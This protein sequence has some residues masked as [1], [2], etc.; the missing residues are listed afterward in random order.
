MALA[1]DQSNGVGVRDPDD[2]QVLPPEQVIDYFFFYKDNK[3]SNKAAKR[4]LEIDQA[5]LSR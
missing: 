1:V 2:A 4:Q 5:G 3:K